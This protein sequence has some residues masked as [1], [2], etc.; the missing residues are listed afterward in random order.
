MNFITFFLDVGN[1]RKYLYA[2]LALLKAHVFCNN[3]RL[4]H[5]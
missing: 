5:G 4:K 2:H 3:V 1:L